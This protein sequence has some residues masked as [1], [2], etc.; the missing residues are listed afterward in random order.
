MPDDEEMWLPSDQDSIPGL[1]LSK[2]NLS[3]MGA[4]VKT[5]VQAEKLIYD[6]ITKV[7]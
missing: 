6:I 4:V 3:G 2:P 5:Q 7:R 1:E